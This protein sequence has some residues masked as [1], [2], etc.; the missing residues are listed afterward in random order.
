MTDHDGLFRL[1]ESERR[2]VRF[3]ERGVVR[4]G[5]LRG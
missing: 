2:H 5:N 1:P 3:G 4:T